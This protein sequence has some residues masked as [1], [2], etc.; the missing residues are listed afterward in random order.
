MS[1]RNNKGNTLL[2]QCRFLILILSSFGLLLT[3]HGQAQLEIWEIQGTGNV[4][5]VIG[6]EVITNGNVVTAVG[7][8]YFFI[9]TPTDRSDNNP[10][11]SDGLFVY[12]D[13]DPGLSVGQVVNVRGTVLEFESMTEI[14]GFGL[15][16]TPT[17]ATAPLPPAVTLDASFPG[18][19]AAEVR[20]FEQVEGMRVEF[21]APVVAPSLG[22]D[23]AALST[24]TQRP[25]REPGIL[26]PGVET[27]PVWDGNPELFWIDPDALNQP[28]NRFL[29]VG[30]S[31][32]ANAVLFQNDD[33][34]VAFP[35]NY[36]VDGTIAERD[37][38]SAAENEI[39]VASFNVLQL[40]DE[41][42]FLDIQYPK[43]ARYIV[44]RL[45]GPDI[46]ALQ[47]VGDI[48]NLNELNFRINQLDPDLR[49]NTYLIQG[50]NNTPINCA[51]LVHESINDVEVSQLAST[52]SIS[53][54]GRL[55]DRP[56]LL[57]EANLPTNP[58]T[59]IQVLNLHLRSLGGIEGSNSFFVRTKRH[60]QAI[61][62]ANLI[63]QRQGNNLIVVGDFNAFQFSDGYVD[64]LSQLEGSSSLGALFP[65]EPVVSPPLANVSTAGAADENYSFVF[66]GSAQVLDHC[67]STN[68]DGMEITEFAYARGNADAASAYFLNPSIT[69]RAS[70]HDG[71]VVYLRPEAP[72]IS[73]VEVVNAL[74]QWKIPNPLASGSTISIPQG[75]TISQLNLFT[76]DGKLIRTW[77]NKLGQITLPELPSGLYLLHYQQGQQVGRVRIVVD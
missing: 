5:P 71:F 39:T 60:E 34:Y 12:T 59:P 43:L 62:V 19:E 11:T 67:L 51:F 72:I 36:S 7:D 65:V 50:N 55:H 54:G 35:L 29:S 25:F 47:E 1:K 13:F 44:D 76:M 75:G 33:I 14:S 4:S 10:T 27:L 15:S 56:P 31:V 53:L 9:Q 45:G 22:N 48:G 16:F 74:D 63:Q 20:D 77:E 28:N 6:Q 8:E 32:T 68:L 49:Y 23:I 42:D 69:I 40:Q 57:L 73:D 26:F 52:E 41:S 24:S 18:T 3:L 30:Q 70:D 38:R 17:G 46:V 58:P 2:E 66:Q 61:S 37:L 64:V 21:T